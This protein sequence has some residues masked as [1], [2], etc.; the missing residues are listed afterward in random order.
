VHKWRSEEAAIL[1]GTKTAL[2]DDPL[3]T[4]RL[5]N[6]KNAIRIV[7]DK[8]LTLLPTLKLFNT[9]SKTL[10]YNLKKTS[11]SENLVCIKLEKDKIIDQIIQSLFEMNIQSLIVEGGSGTLQSFIDAGLWDEARVIT[12]LELIIPNG[13]AAPEMK[14]FLLESQQEYDGDVINFYSRKN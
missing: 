14:G 8:N 9:D 13:I 3:L 7:I 10:I 2:Q 6:G 12:N 5:W 4:T 11:T 1:V